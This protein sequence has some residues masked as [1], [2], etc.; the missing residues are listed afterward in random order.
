MHNEGFTNPIVFIYKFI[1]LFLNSHMIENYI[2][3]IGWIIKY[4]Y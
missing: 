2:F 1:F 4:N 3:L